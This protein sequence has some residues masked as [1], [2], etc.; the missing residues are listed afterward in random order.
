LL[1]RS[2]TLLAKRQKTPIRLA[3]TA[4]KNGDPQAAVFTASKILT[5]KPAAAG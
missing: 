2:S 5:I 1:I 4:N 3:N